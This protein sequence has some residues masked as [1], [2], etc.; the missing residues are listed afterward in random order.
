MKIPSRTRVKLKNVSIYCK[1]L[2]DPNKKLIQLFSVGI[3]GEEGLTDSTFR[4]VLF[5]NKKYKWERVD[6]WIGDT[7]MP[8]ALI[9]IIGDKD[10]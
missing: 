4:Q 6:L 2:E 7:V 1:T 10:A 5:S 3:Y 9:A 8:D